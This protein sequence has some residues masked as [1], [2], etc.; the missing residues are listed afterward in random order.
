MSYRNLLMWIGPP[1]LI[2]IV[3]VLAI[4]WPLSAQMRNGRQGIETAM[5]E[6][7]DLEASVV[8]MTQQK[9]TQE[10]LQRSY[11]DFLRQAPA[12][13]RIGDYMA[14]VVGAAKARGMGVEEV[15]GYYG[16]MDLT[17]KNIINPVFELTLRG[18][19]LDMGRFLEE[20]S[21]QMAY[22]SVLKARIASD[23]NDQYALAGRFV[24]EFKALKR[25]SLEGK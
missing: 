4:Y 25:R 13:D 11:D 2:I 8:A 5:Q 14:S 6:R 7:K 15:S 12:I 1:V 17:R 24:L 22:K 18:G 16:S 20:L 19:Y 10:Q 9:Q 3:W 21:Q 23:E